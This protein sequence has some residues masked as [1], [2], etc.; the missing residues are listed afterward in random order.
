MVVFA[1]LFVLA[2]VGIQVW[3]RKGMELQDYLIYIA[4]IFFLTMSICYLVIIHKVYM[5]GKVTVGL[6]A[7]WPTIKTDIIIYVRMMFVTTT[8]FWFSLWSVKLSLLTL[9]KKLMDG[10]PKVYM[11]LWWAVFLFCLVVC[12]HVWLGVCPY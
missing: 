3:K 6:I 4:F 12:S 7:P 11:R 10:V 2:R 1:S 5:I 9:Y 8:L